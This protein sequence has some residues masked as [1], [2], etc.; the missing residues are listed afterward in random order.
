MKL[1]EYFMKLVSVIRG[2]ENHLYLCVC[3]C[4]YM[5]MHYITTLHS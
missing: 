5:R 4:V 3:A 2:I 1:L